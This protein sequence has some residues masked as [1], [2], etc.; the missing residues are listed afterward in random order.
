[1]TR[2]VGW[3]IE[4]GTLADLRAMSSFH[5]ARSLPHAPVRV[6]RAVERRAGLGGGPGS[7]SG[8]GPGS[9]RGGLV[10][11]LAVSRPVLNAS[12]RAT[13]WPGVFDGFGNSERARAINAHL[14]TIS[15]VIVEPRHR[16]MGVGSMLVRAYLAS[17]ETVLTETI[18]SMARYTSLFARC[19][20]RRVEFPRAARD[21]RLL[22]AL[23]ARGRAPYELV[24]PAR[25]R[26]LMRDASI[27][28]AVDRW[29]NA[30]R[31]TRAALAMGRVDRA[32][33]AG[34]G[35]IARPVVYVHGDVSEVVEREEV[36]R[37][38]PMNTRGILR[39]SA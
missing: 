27:R 34:R 19:G 25:A 11:V 26:L 10:G 17:R 31:G 20:M 35:L 4:E 32:S 39:R 3:V 9:G 22:L 15:R 12:W 38:V 16:S 6:L 13:A 36:E 33:I 2:V 7:G 5:Y 21:E 1:M 23:G 30:S 37:W 18:A 24:D 14:R 29:L 8:C 28:V